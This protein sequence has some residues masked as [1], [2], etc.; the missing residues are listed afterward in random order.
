MMSLALKT[1]LDLNLIDKDRYESIVLRTLANKD[2]ITI[3]DL[4]NM[5]DL[6]KYFG[7]G[8][9]KTMLILELQECVRQLRSCDSDTTLTV[10]KYGANNN[11]SDDILES[12]IIEQ[13]ASIPVEEIGRYIKCGTIPQSVQKVGVSSLKD[14]WYM[15]F[16]SIATKGFCK[17]KE[18]NIVRSQSVDITN[19]ENKLSD[20]QT[21]FNK[22]VD[23]AH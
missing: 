4:L 11:H 18:L 10:K 20:F 16:D 9:K 1:L 21:K 13:L 5:Q 6:S 23:L 14:L 17:K 8:K 12:P 2:I 22:N 3:E 7:I 19:F 15:D